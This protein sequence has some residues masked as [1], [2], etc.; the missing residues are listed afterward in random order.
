M[1][2]VAGWARDSRHLREVVSIPPQFLFLESRK[3]GTVAAT[4]FFPKMVPNTAVSRRKFGHSQSGCFCKKNC[5]FHC[6]VTREALSVFPDGP[7]PCAALR[8]PENMIYLLIEKAPYLS[9][10]HS[11]V[12]RGRRGRLGGG[13]GVE[14]GGWTK[15]GN[16]PLCHSELVVD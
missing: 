4:K 8:S 13:N 1:R 6:S 7:F 10:G 14:R 9:R 16:E 3:D 12:H 11:V 2:Q 15:C 5:L